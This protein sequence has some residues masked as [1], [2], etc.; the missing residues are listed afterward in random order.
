MKKERDFLL[1]FPEGKGKRGYGLA[2][3]PW[4]GRGEKEKKRVMISVSGEKAAWP[5]EETKVLLVEERKKGGK[6]VPWFTKK[7]LTGGKKKRRGVLHPN[8][9]KK[10]G[11]FSA[12]KTILTGQGGE[13]RGEKPFRHPARGMKSPSSVAGEHRSVKEE[14]NIPPSVMRGTN[15]TLGDVDQGTK[16]TNTTNKKTNAEYSSKQKEG[17]KIHLLPKNLNQK[18][19]S[20]SLGGVLL[21]LM[22][23][24]TCLLLENRRT[25]NLHTNATS[26]TRGKKRL[27]S[28]FEGVQSR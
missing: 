10:G 14:K 17:E 12:T 6:P 18:G 15:L 24:E 8:G 26:L 23:K 13:W 7:R 19:Y 21:D 4:E 22:I 28:I 16:R 11:N 20:Y 3:L 1:L 27:I 25:G 9:R 2:P 5:S